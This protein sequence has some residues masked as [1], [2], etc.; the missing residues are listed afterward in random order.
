LPQSPWAER[1]QVFGH[2]LKAETIGLPSAAVLSDKSLRKGVAIAMCGVLET[3]LALAAGL[4]P[5][6]AQ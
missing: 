1:G 2:P 4:A 3:I 5:S 6:D